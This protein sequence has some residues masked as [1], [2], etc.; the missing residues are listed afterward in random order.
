MS[1]CTREMSRRLTRL[2]WRS[3]W[4]QQRRPCS[5]KW[6]E[7]L[8]E[9][10]VDIVRTVSFLGCEW[11]RC[12]SL[13]QTAERKMVVLPSDMLLST[14]KKHMRR[15]L[16]SAWS[17]LS[18][19]SRGLPRVEGAWFWGTDKDGQTQTGSNIHNAVK[20]ILRWNRT[21]KTRGI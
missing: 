12:L 3:P 7:H 2:E 16:I 14:C 15:L 8:E 10:V 4:A 6:T 20:L 17:S 21:E 18:H 19:R 13:T 9:T 11:T 5:S 1:L